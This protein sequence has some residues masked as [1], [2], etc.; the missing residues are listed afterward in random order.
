MTFH[1][2]F[3]MTDD[4]ILDVNG[5]CITGMTVTEVGQ[6]ICN[7][8][9]EFLATVRPITTL[10][11][12]RPPDVMR[13]NYTTILPNLVLQGSPEPKA[14]LDMTS[15]SDSLD[16]VGNYD[17]EDDEDSGRSVETGGDPTHK[18]SPLTG[19]RSCFK[20]LE[21]TLCIRALGY[22]KRAIDMKVKKQPMHAS[23]NLCMYCFARNSCTNFRLHYLQMH[24]LY[25]IEHPS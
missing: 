1:S 17:D 2:T 10:K 18:P 6:V 3:F 25:N 12:F 11:K 22:T 9:D 24:L 4:E 16:D 8:P 20:V 21:Y 5:T 19:K 23:A 13:V 7:C 15:S 14:R